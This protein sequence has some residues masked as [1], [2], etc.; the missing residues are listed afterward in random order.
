MKSHAI[1]AIKTNIKYRKNEL[2]DTR[3][4]SWGQTDRRAE[5]ARSIDSL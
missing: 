4:T 3:V 2:S 1:L 5:W